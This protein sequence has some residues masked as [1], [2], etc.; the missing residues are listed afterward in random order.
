MIPRSY[1]C[2]LRWWLCHILIVSLKLTRRAC[3]LTA[4][5]PI[6]S[7]TAPMS[8]AMA[9]IGILAIPQGA[10]LH[11]DLKCPHRPPQWPV[12]QWLRL[13]LHRLHPRPRWQWDE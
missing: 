5:V 7:A 8:G 3:A 2:H 1:L 12:Q 6:I 11:P 13:L 9:R 10:P 4:W